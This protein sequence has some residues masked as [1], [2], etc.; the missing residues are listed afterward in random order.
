MC[1]IGPGANWRLLC[2]G[3]TTVCSCWED[4]IS[5]F[6]WKKKYTM[7]LRRV[8]VTLNLSKYWIC[9]GVISLM[10]MLS[11]HEK[12]EKKEI[13]NKQKTRGRKTWINSRKIWKA[14]N[15]KTLMA[16]V[17]YVKV[18]SMNSR[19]NLMYESLRIIYSLNFICLHFVISAHFST[20][21]VWV[22]VRLC[23]C[24]AHVF[25]YVQ[26]WR[27]NV[28]TDILAY[29]LDKILQF[30]VA[31]SINNHLKIAFS[32]PSS[33]LPDKFFYELIIWYVT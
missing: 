26:K 29:P 22:R 14:F 9:L 7:M 27:H 24:S 12:I 19:I 30:N 25:A 16:T 33:S 21:A 6:P 31:R 18:L 13:K 28:Q 17:T 1:C 15:A 2:G 3:L 8:K 20:L 32:I 10:K 5:S 4:E 11:F 23:W